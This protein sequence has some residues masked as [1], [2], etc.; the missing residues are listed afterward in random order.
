[1][2]CGR[3]VVTRSSAD[4]LCWSS[5]STLL[6]NLPSLLLSPLSFSLF[7]SP[8]LASPPSD[9][10]PENPRTVQVS[11]PFDSVPLIQRPPF[12]P[13]GHGVNLW[14][15]PHLLPCCYIA[16][17]ANPCLLPFSGPDTSN[18]AFWEARLFAPLVSHSP[19]PSDILST[20][21][22]ILDVIT[23]A[24]QDVANPCTFR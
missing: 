16:S 19:L 13:N 4:P 22:I 1:M 9:L 23:P 17:Y 11:I 21:T 20:Q 18:S 10:S 6:C 2:T 12:S 3:R 24:R 14:T 5:R 8:S 7:L 15:S